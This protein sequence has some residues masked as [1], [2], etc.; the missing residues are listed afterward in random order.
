MRLEQSPAKS[1]MS[2]GNK[3]RACKVFE[4]MCHQLLAHYSSVKHKMLQE[5]KF[6]H[7]GERG[8]GNGSKH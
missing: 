4:Y 2:D 6:R 5:F 8:S 1:T 3:K 7:S